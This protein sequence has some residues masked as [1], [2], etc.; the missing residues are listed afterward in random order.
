MA[1]KQEKKQQQQI[2]WVSMWVY[3]CFGFANVAI[4]TE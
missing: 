2:E 3:E 4:A 1:T